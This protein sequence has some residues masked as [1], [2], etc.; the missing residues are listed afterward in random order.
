M[1][2]TKK[3]STT[4]VCPSASERETWMGA[5]KAEQTAPSGVHRTNSATGLSGRKGIGSKSASPS[6]GRPNRSSDPKISLN[7]APSGVPSLSNAALGHAAAEFDLVMAT[8]A[9]YADVKDVSKKSQLLLELAE[10]LLQAGSPFRATE[11]ARSAMQIQLD[12]ETATDAELMNR[13]ARM[14][15]RAEEH[16]L[17]G[18]VGSETSGAGW[19]AFNKEIM[20]L[21]R[22]LKEGRETLSESIAE[23]DTDLEERT[24]RFAHDG[25][26]KVLVP[27][28]NAV[29]SNM[30][31]SPTKYTVAVFELSASL[32]DRMPYDGVNVGIVMQDYSPDNQRYFSRALQLIALKLA[33][34]GETAPVLLCENWKTG[35]PGIRLTTADEFLGLE[36]IG[37]VE[38]FLKL[39]E[40]EYEDTHS[41]QTVMLANPHFVSGDKAL[42]KRYSKEVQSLLDSYLLIPVSHNGVITYQEFAQAKL[43]V[44]KKLEQFEPPN[45]I[46]RI[47]AAKFLG[48]IGNRWCGDLFL[49]K[50]HAF[51]KMANLK[52]EFWLPMHGCVAALRM[53]HGVSPDLGEEPALEALH[54]EHTV[55][56]KRSLRH[57]RGAIEKLRKYQLLAQLNNE[58]TNE[59]LYHAGVGHKPP[60]AWEISGKYLEKVMQIYQ[61]VLPLVIGADDYF[62]S[63]VLTKNTFNLQTLQ[64]ETPWVRLLALQRMGLDEEALKDCLALAEGQA[65]SMHRIVSVAEDISNTRIAMGDFNGAV[66]DLGMLKEVCIDQKARKTVAAVDGKL[67]VVLDVSGHPA[68]A[69]KFRDR[70]LEFM[71]STK[72]AKR[73]KLCLL[74]NRGTQ[75][76]SEGHQED[77]IA[78][79]QAVLKQASSTRNRR[80]HK[81]AIQLALPDLMHN[82]GACY[83]MNKQYNEALAAFKDEYEIVIQRFGSESMEVAFCRLNSAATHSSMGD[84]ALAKTV[85]YQGA[86]T[87]CR[88]FGRSDEHVAACQE[89]CADLYAS[90][91]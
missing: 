59:Y 31:K 58:S 40:V 61:T 17:T 55:L 60:G 64:L 35:F 74:V 32:E 38:Q 88:V 19:D 50:D 54:K 69:K 29:F 43:P 11:F 44:K 82:L 9:V 76:M 41:L 30:P 26:H 86:V 67:S 72:T 81:R 37:G 42:F 79:F 51:P 80:L 14:M 71:E 6:L 45:Q 52:D 36:L 5:L 24:H 73:D 23:K 39:F 77:A 68:E 47:K 53:L 84:L 78:I 63:R 91:K 56:G 7:A 70:A 85:A 16:V 57:L 48:Y 90:S 15:Q 46:R 33:Q 62:H 27:L 4:I 18:V 13:A 10:K 34:L 75:L 12:V 65:Y 2:G 28:V 20:P 66:V 49:V 3:G 22:L 89:F 8:S 87:F 1:L 21:V 25:I 83:M